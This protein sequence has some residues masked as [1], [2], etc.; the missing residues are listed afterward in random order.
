MTDQALKCHQTCIGHTNCFSIT[1]DYHNWVRDA[2][3]GFV[4]VRLF[5][6][7]DSDIL[8]HWIQERKA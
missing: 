2:D 8:Q 5:Y 4:S 7:I 1:S 6:D 3:M